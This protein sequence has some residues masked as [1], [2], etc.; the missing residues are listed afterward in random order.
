MP[1]P[2][3]I[4]I[5]LSV[6]VGIIAC[7]LLLYFLLNM[8]AK[9]TDNMLDDDIIKYARWPT[10]LL[11]PTIG[12]LA[13]T[14]ILQLE[15]STYNTLHHALVIILI[16]ALT[17]LVM[18]LIKIITHFVARKH[19]WTKKE[20]N[21]RSRQAMT[22]SVVIMRT[23]SGLVIVVGIGA[24][25]LTFPQVYTVGASLLAS[26]G[27]LSLI[28]GMSAKPIFENMVASL[29]IALTQPITLD[30]EVL[31]DGEYGRIEEIGSLYVVV[32]T[33]DERRLVIPLSRFLTQTFENWTLKSPQKL[34]YV[35]LYL[36]YSIPIDEIREK[37]RQYCEESIYWDGRVALV[38]VTDATEKCIQ[39]RLLVSARTAPLCTD[40]RNELREKMIRYVNEKY[41]EALPVLRCHIHKHSEEAKDEGTVDGDP[42]GAWRM[43]LQENEKTE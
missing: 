18:N 8:V 25:A 39:V 26:A 5:Y 40:L 23:L 14:S 28:V 20:N 33:W 31:I 42:L 24:I 29:Q 15:E 32:R 12:A 4:V 21:L 36:D 37:L 22:Q 3:A 6:I 1:S 35:Y 11:F 17:W 2:V 16:I 13:S 9:R 34:G 27:I 38:H 19:D 41:P 30:D 7:Q 10:L 43:G